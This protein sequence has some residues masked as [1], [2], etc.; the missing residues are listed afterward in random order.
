MNIGSIMPFLLILRSFYVRFDKT[1]IIM[2]ILLQRTK[3][4]EDYTEGKLFVDGVYVC[5]T[6]EDAER[7]L[8]QSMSEE[9]ITEKKVYEKTAIPTGRYK[10]TIDWS[11]KFGKMLIH[12][13]NVKG[14]DGI[15]V[16]SGN[17]AGDSFGCVLVGLRTSN[18]WVS[19]S[20]KTYAIL[21]KMVEDGLKNG[22][23]YITIA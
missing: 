19:S 15:R 6:I 20:R 10:V 7:G 17:S 18:G 9:E 5:D 11:N 4:T 14:F 16:H 8:D 13:L 22:C 23:V 12:I 3:K 2:E 1:T 21:H